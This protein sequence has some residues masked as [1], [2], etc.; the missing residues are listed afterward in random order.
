MVR[1]SK[2]RRADDESTSIEGP[3]C[4]CGKAGPLRN[5]IQ[6]HVRA[7]ASARGKG[8]GC[9][10]CGLHADGAMAVLC[11]ACVGQL[12]R[13]GLPRKIGTIRWACGGYIGEPER[14]EYDS[15][16]EPFDHDMSRHE[17]LSEADLIARDQWGYREG[18]RW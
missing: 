5:L 11:D 4:G 6:L 1:E 17:R 18:G 10:V 12:D 8:W 2:R 13:N 7:P 15:L 9:V 14:V 16:T 3:C